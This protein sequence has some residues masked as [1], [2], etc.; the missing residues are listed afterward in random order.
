MDVG[1]LFSG[2]RPVPSCCSMVVGSTSRNC[3]EVLF[4]EKVVH[5][6]EDTKTVESAPQTSRRA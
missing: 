2:S 1:L 4:L 5:K 3:V 6:A